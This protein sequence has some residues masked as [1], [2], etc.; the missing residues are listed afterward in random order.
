MTHTHNMVLDYPMHSTAR[1]QNMLNIKQLHK[2]CRYEQHFIHHVT[3]IY[4]SLQVI[5]NQSSKH[6]FCN[7]LI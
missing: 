6:I 7:D 3:T 2:L 1:L 5:Q 4:T